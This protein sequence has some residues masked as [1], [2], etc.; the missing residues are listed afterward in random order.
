MDRNKIFISYPSNDGIIAQCVSAAISKM[1]NGRLEYFLDRI[2]IKG[3]ARIPDTIREALRQTVY[4]VAI[5]TD[6]LRRNFDWCG[7]ELGFYQASHPDDNRLET[8][9]YDKTIPELFVERKSYKVQALKAEHLDELG[10]PIIKAAESEIYHFLVRT[11]ELNAELYPPHPPEQYWKDVPK[12]AEQYACEIADSFLLALQSRV[13]DEW[14]PQGRIELS[15]SRGEFYKDNIPSVPLDTQVTMA[16]SAYKLFRAASPAS[17]KTFTW[18]SFTKYIKEKTGSDQLIRIVSDVI[19]NALP[20]KDE[21]KND[22]VFQ[23][24]N[25]K[26]YRVILVKHSVYGDGR[27]DFVINLI[28]TSEKVKAGDTDTTTL[29]AGIVLGSKYRSIFV[30]EDAKYN[31]SK[32]KDLETDNLVDKLK[33]M[34]RD[35]D[36]ISADAASDGLADYDALQALLGDTMQVKNLFDKWFQVY[37]P[38]EAAAKK[39]ITEPTTP[40]RDAFFAAYKPFLAVSRANNATFLLL[41]MDEYRK[42]LR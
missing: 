23:A 11:A 34:L 13:R 21:A 19:I 20:D 27:R 5:G 22:Y 25:G 35:I 37:P 36:R 15:I 41:C 30:E 6:V 2:Y 32:L 7:Q 31:E 33:Q 17:P 4:F 29:V 14:F 18:D 28:E 24:P 38:M 40:H 12:W 8:C 9:L 3:G 16:N 26:F 39:F 10:F 1:P 42:R